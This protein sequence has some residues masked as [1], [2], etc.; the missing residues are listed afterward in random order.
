MRRS[1]TMKNDAPNPDENNQHTRLRAAREKLR[2]SASEA[3]RSMGMNI[4]TY[5]HHENGTRTYG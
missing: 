5:T 3:A 1:A 2:I 4:S